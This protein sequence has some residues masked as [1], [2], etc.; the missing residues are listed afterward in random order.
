MALNL[1]RQDPAARCA[2]KKRLRLRRKAVGWGDDA[3]MALLGLA[4][5]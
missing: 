4:P 1:L 3:R 5:L 2:P